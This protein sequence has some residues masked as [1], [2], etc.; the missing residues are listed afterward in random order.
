[1]KF[2]DIRRWLVARGEISPRCREVAPY[3]YSQNGSRKAAR[4]PGSVFHWVVREA[5]RLGWNNDKT[6]W[7]TSWCHTWPRTVRSLETEAEGTELF[8]EA[9]AYLENYQREA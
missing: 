4:S 5:R 1:M 3:Y 9:Y 8:W 7:P 2:V 6:A